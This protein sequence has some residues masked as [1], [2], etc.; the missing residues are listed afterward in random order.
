MI[1]Y[2]SVHYHIISNKLYDTISYLMIP[3]H[4][5]Q[6]YY[7]M[8]ISFHNSNEF[9]EIGIMIIYII[10]IHS[11]LCK[12]IS[13]TQHVRPMYYPC[14]YGDNRTSSN[15]NMIMKEHMLQKLNPAPETLVQIQ[16]SM[17]WRESVSQDAPYMRV[18]WK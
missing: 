17:Q 9:I 18:W 1:Q 11:H 13:I 12:R 2:I 10:Y 16:Q 8:Q 5:V 6:E 14:K 7:I 15:W 3:Y 4:I